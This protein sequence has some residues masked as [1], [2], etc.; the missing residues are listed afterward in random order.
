M[1]TTI[2]GNG[3]SPNFGGDNGPA[4]AAQ[5]YS[6]SGIAIDSSGN[7]YIA[8][9]SNNRIRMVTPAGVISTIAGTGTAGS[10]GDNGPA[11]AAELNG[12]RSLACDIFG[13]LY[14]ADSGNNE[15][16]KMT[17]GG[18]IATLPVATQ[19]NNPVSVATDAEGSVYIADSGNNRIVKVTA[20]G[21]AGMFATIAG[22]Q[23]LAVDPSGN[24]LVADSTQIWTITPAG[25]ASS[26]ITGLSSPTGITVASDGSLLIAET[27]ANLILQWTA[28]GSLATIAGTGTAG[29]SGDGGPALAAQLNGPAGIAM[30]ANGVFWIADSGNNRIRSL[31]PASLPWQRPR[32]PSQWSTRPASPLD[33]SRLVKSSPCLVRASTPPRPNSCSTARRRRCSTPAQRKST[34]SRP[35]VCPPTPAAW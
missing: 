15:V 16:R 24:V 9:T 7:W 19:L 26:M 30:G 3:A 13:N 27:G 21:T 1:V 5:L 20:A 12:P 6:P 22:P 29:F 14:V 8:D 28:S 25:V 32:R 31:T 34:R 11:S 18:L 17:P 35:P 33:P 23:A 4:I 2:A 10:T